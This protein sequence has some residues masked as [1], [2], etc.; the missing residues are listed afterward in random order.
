MHRRFEEAI[1]RGGDGGGGGGRDGGGGGGGDG[2]DDDDDDDDVMMVM[3][4]ITVA[5]FVHKK[6]KPLSYSLS[7]GWVAPWF[8]LY[9]R[10]K[11]VTLGSIRP[12][13]PITSVSSR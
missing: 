1:C 13:P 8:D 5:V 10:T 4:M 11:Y 6:V 2:D 7:P 9:K 3:M 12:P